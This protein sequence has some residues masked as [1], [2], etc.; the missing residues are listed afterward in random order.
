MF[1]VFLF[2]FSSAAVNSV[3]DLCDRVILS[4]MKRP[5]V[6][7]WFYSEK[8]RRDDRIRISRST[9]RGGGRGGTWHTTFDRPARTVFC[10]P[11][12]SAQRTLCANAGPPLL[13]WTRRWAEPC[14]RVT[15]RRPW[16]RSTTVTQLKT[17]R[18]GCCARM[19]TGW[20][21]W[22]SRSRP[23][24]TPCPW[25][26]STARRRPWTWRPSTFQW[27]WNTVRTCRRNGRPNILS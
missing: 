4:Y 1:G 21:P 25:W 10:L 27:T 17:A 13:Q 20:S 12:V 11:V 22:P 19:S 2:I 16:S 8:P 14:V 5:S 26:W 6:F 24:W 9:I 23:I 18:G 7:H 3:T 15:S